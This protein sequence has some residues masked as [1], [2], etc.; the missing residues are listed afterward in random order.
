MER[1]NDV[2]DEEVSTI[3]DSAGDQL[4]QR[5]SGVKSDDEDEEEDDDDKVCDLNNTGRTIVAV[6][7]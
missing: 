7:V 1:L 4:S 6:S 5:S 2:S 3:V